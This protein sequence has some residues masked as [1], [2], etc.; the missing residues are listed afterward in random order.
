VVGHLG[1]T[2]GSLAM[3]TDTN[4]QAMLTAGEL[5][6]RG[7][8]V[9]VR[10][11]AR[12]RVLVSWIANTLAEVEASS[13]DMKDFVGL[14]DECEVDLDGPAAWRALR[15]AAGTKGRELDIP[16]LVSRLGA[17]DVVPPDLV[18]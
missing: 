10:R 2:L 16:A 9:E 18:D 15:H 12:Q 6:R 17:R 7:I 5:R 1:R 3:L 8:E 13:L 11:S 4:G 14:L